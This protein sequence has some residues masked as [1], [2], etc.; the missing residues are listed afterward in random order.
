MSAWG[1]FVS[2]ENFFFVSP[3]FIFR[4]DVGAY[5]PGLN[6]L[7]LQFAKLWRSEA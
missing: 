7:Y 6:F 3:F 5:V 2:G 4:T 1:A